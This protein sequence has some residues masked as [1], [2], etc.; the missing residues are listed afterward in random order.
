[1]N[2]LPAIAI[3]LAYCLRPVEFFGKPGLGTGLTRSR[4]VHAFGQ[5]STMEWLQ[6]GQ[7]TVKRG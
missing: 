5:H 4:T 3:F 6:R 7:E 2:G 1:M